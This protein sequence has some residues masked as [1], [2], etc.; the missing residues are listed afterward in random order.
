M[1]CRN[2]TKQE[3]EVKDCWTESELSG[4][5]LRSGLGKGQASMVVAVIWTDLCAEVAIQKSGT[6]RF[7]RVCESKGVLERGGREKRKGRGQG[8]P[9]HFKIPLDPF[10]AAQKMCLMSGRI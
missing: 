2:G 7:C 9:E 1:D 8:N 4:C 10:E 6:F 3:F 5:C